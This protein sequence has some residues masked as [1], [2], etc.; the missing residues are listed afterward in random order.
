M[1]RSPLSL[2]RLSSPLV[3]L[4]LLLWALPFLGGAALEE[5]AKAFSLQNKGHLPLPRHPILSSFELP[6][7]D[8]SIVGHCS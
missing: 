7:S 4:L 1:L 2:R 5:L 3:L 8:V 6:Y